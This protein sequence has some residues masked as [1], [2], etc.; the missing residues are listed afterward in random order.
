VKD[1]LVLYEWIRMPDSTGFGDYTETG[2]V[3]PCTYKG[4]EM[5]FVLQMYLDVL[6]PILAGREIWGF[7]KE[8]ADP[9]LEVVKETLTGT[10]MYSGQQLAM[11]TM[12][13]KAETIDLKEIKKSMEKTNVNLKIIPGA[14]G[15]LEIAQLV[16][17]N[18]IN[19]NV[20]GAWKGDARLH[21]I[22]HIHASVADLPVRKIVGAK[23][24][25]ADLTL[26]Y[27]RIL[28][29]YMDKKK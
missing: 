19:I 15:E 8:Y 1:P 20:K 9:K 23:H 4:E 27:G 14:N 25:I 21:L 6:P 17:Y 7:P 3:L 18:L 11:G 22:P 29:N 10:L 26:P 5:S 24:F 12:V 16:A 13:Y 2:I 28:H